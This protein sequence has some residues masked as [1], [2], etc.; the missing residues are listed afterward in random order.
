MAWFNNVASIRTRARI[1]SHGVGG[2]ISGNALGGAIAARARLGAHPSL[3]LGGNPETALGSVV[4]MSVLALGLFGTALGS[5]VL[6]VHKVERAMSEF[7]SNIQTLSNNTG[8]GYGQSIGVQGRFGAFG[9]NAAEMFSG[10]E[11]M[12]MFFR[13]KAQGYGLPGYEDPNFISRLAERYQAQARQGPTG[14]LMART[15]LQ[16]LGLDSP[17]MLNTV[18]LSPRRIR[19]QQQFQNRMQGAFG[20]DPAAIRRWAEEF[21]LLQARVG[22]FFQ[23]LWVKIGTLVSP[24]ILGALNLATNLMERFGGT[25]GKGLQKGAEIGTYWIGKVL[26]LFYVYGPMA[27]LAVE[28]A[29]LKML[30]VVGHIAISIAALYKNTIGRFTPGI[31]GDMA[32]K[33]PQ[34]LGDASLGA[35]AVTDW[36]TGHV[37]APMEDHFIVDSA[38][39]IGASATTRRNTPAAVKHRAANTVHHHIKASHMGLGGW[40]DDTLNPFIAHG[41]DNLKFF[42]RPMPGHHYGLDDLKEGAHYVGGGMG[43]HTQY[44]QKRSADIQRQ[45]QAIQAWKA[46]G[47][48]PRNRPVTPDIPAE[49]GGYQGPEDSNFIT[50]FTDPKISEI[51][52]QIAQINTGQRQQEWDKIWGDMLKEIK[53]LRQDIDEK[54]GAV[55]F[56]EFRALMKLLGR[57]MG[58]DILRTSYK[59]GG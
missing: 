6:T 1:S 45:H 7:S 40:I 3:M 26:G 18:N 29:A 56:P 8:M 17:E 55:G 47:A 30:S 49:Q 59:G 5:I 43:S 32:S 37:A 13:A 35:Q 22:S 15:M 9:M 2:T 33:V 21:P 34:A 41:I 11:N 12:P 51:D 54:S 58:S 24:Y 4:Q 42:L 36:V 19:E 14:L 50:A 10:T 44:V 38:H 31:L 27:F 39:G 16:N 48:N 46:S 52:K 53:G 23:L 28:S 57:E 20:L 25:I